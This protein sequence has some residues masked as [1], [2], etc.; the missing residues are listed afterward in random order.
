[1][2]FRKRLIETNIAQRLVECTLEVA[3]EMGAF[4][5]AALRAGLDGSALWCPKDHDET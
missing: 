1:V 2:A 3:K 5:S 4:G